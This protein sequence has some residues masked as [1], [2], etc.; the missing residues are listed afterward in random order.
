[1]QHTIATHGPLQWHFE[2]ASIESFESAFF[3]CEVKTERGI[4][5]RTKYAEMC[6]TPNAALGGLDTVKKKISV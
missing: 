4:P 3:Q 6:T 2:R 1:M 5:I